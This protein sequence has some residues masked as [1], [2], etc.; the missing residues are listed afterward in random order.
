MS[1]QGDRKIILGIAGLG[2]VGAGVVKIVEKHK[3]LLAARAG[4]PVEIRAVSARDRSRDRGVDLAPYDW[5]D[6]PVD[7]ASEESGVNVVVE[8]IGGSDGPAL[9]LARKALG[10]GIGF[11][12]ANKALI[13]THGKELAALAEETGAPLKFEAAVAGGIPI[14]KALREGLA[15]NA[16]ESVRGIL[17]G[18]CNYILTRMEQEGLAFDEVLKDAQALG[19]AEADPTFDIDGIDT[20]HKTAILA[21]LA[22]GTEPDIENL[23]TEGIRNIAPVDIEYAK[24]LGYRIKLLG[25]TQQTAEGIETRVHPAMV[26]TRAA[27]ANVMGPTNAVVVDGDAVGQT[28]YEGAGAGEGPTAS[29]VLA[30]ILDVARGA[31]GPRLGVP[32]VSLTPS[33][34]VPVSKHRGTYY[35]RLRVND[36]PGVMADI[37]K[38]LAEE[39]VSIESMLQRGSASDG[40]VYIVLTTHETVEASV[41]ATL[42]RFT[43]LQCVLETPTMLRIEA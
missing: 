43:T 29:A 33:S 9:A 11:V 3:A 23:P 6:N 40:G 34:P 18:T 8:L 12:T 5:V 15:G 25:V 28:V 30:D 7:L 32:A 4:C 27:I 36:Q 35:I 26:P 24:E 19:Y 42:D 10:R 37:T 41:A 22:F 14:I 13:A 31:A 39:S 2:T 20:A 17:N 16:I 21:T 1:K 38:V